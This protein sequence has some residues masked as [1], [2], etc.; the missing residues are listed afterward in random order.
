[1]V[2]EESPAQRRSNVQYDSQQKH[3]MVYGGHGAFF[4]SGSVSGFWFLVSE[5]R[6]GYTAPNRMDQELGGLC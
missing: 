3:I 2:P 6:V 4:S 5:F 1:M